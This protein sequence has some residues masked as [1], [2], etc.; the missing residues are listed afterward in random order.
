VHYSSVTNIQA[1]PL[2]LANETACY[3]VDDE[4]DR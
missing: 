2:Y 1:A 3:E 4:T